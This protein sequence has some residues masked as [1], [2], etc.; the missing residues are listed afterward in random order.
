MLESYRC[1]GSGDGSAAAAVDRSTPRNCC[2]SSLQ[3]WNRNGVGKK[4]NESFAG[5]HVK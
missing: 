2:P 3:T 4:K 5:E 1:D